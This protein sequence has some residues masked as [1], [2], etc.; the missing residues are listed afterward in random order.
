MM[1]CDVEASLED[2][3]DGCLFIGVII[4]SGGTQRN[5]KKRGGRGRRMDSG[6]THL[7]IVAVMERR[8][9]LYV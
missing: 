4:V 2:D 1:R 9:T 5:G 8:I 7:Y 6:E 3:G